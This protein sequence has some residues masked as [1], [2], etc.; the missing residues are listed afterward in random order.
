MNQP[1][2]YIVLVGLV[3]IVYAR[4]VPRSSGNQGSKSQ[5]GSMLSEMEETMDHFAAELDEQNKALIQMV[6]ETKKEYELHSAKLVYRI[7]TLEK[8]GSQLQQEI[9][10]IGYVCEQLQ[11]RLSDQTRSDAGNSGE[12]AGSV[13]PERHAEA[14]NAASPPEPVTQEPPAVSFVSDM[15]ERYSELFALYQQG[16]S[17]DYIAKKLGKNKGEINLILQLAKQEELSD[18]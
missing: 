12:T 1:W 9:S 6:A 5:S 15:K 17:T 3:L 14:A 2:I 10:R 13:E 11:A 4:M 18:G 7:E 8:Q 16:K